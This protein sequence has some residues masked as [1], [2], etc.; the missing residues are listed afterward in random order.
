[1]IIRALMIILGALMIIMAAL[2]IILGALMI[3]DLYQDH[4]GNC[5]CGPDGRWAQK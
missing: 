2:M 1:M 4:Q 3:N 5:C